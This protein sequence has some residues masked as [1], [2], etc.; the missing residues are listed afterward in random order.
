M[1]LMD[2]D[3]NLYSHGPKMLLLKLHP[4]TGKLTNTNLHHLRLQKAPNWKRPPKSTFVSWKKLVFSASIYLIKRLQHC[5]ANSTL[6]SPFNCTSCRQGFLHPTMVLPV[7]PK[8]PCFQILHGRNHSRTHLKTS[9]LHVCI[10]PWS[11]REA[12]RQPSPISSVPPGTKLPAPMS[13]RK[14]M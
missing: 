7:A 1:D 4:S 10:A 2:T 9:A 5:S 6:Q 12:E 14:K 11:E 13:L 8:L 3:W